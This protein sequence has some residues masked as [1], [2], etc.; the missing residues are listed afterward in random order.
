MAFPIKS[1]LQTFELTNKLVSAV[2]Q[3]A[4]CDCAK[5]REIVHNIQICADVE[6]PEISQPGSSNGLAVLNA[7]AEVTGSAEGSIGAKNFGNPFGGVV[8]H[9]LIEP[10]LVPVFLD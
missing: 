5:L 2:E 7:S 4:T 8:V 9:G 3:R 10:G 6:D 1:N